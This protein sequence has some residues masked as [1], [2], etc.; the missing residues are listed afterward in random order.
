MKNI[1]HFVFILFICFTVFTSCDNLTDPIVE[2]NQIVDYLEKGFKSKIYTA[3]LIPFHFDPRFN[4]PKTIGGRVVI[5]VETE[6]GSI[7]YRVIAY[8]LK[9]NYYYYI[10]ISDKIKAPVANL[11]VCQANNGGHLI[12]SDNLKNFKP[13]EYLYVNI[14]T[15]DKMILHTYNIELE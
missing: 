9:A 10:N 3:E 7:N 15:E 1:S 14:M 6:S 5:E 4:E 2:E 13:Y 8:G 11:K 12:M